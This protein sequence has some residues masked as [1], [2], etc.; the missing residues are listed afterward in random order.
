MPPGAHCRAVSCHDWTECGTDAAE[1]RSPAGGVRSSVFDRERIGQ[2]ARRDKHDVEREKQLE[3]RSG[4][5]DWPAAQQLGRRLRSANHNRNE[6]E[7]ASIGS[8]NSASLVWH[9]PGASENV[10]PATA[11]VVPNTRAS[12]ATSTIGGGESPVDFVEDIRLEPCRSG[13]SGAKRYILAI[14][15]TRRRPTTSRQ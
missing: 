6:N 1:R 7:S 14:P 9:S 4:L 11:R 13:E 2:G 5:D 10:T 12:S 15:P 8:S 3:P